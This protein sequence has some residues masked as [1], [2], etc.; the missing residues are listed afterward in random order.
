MDNLITNKFVLRAMEALTGQ[1]VYFGVDKQFLRFDANV[2]GLIEDE[3]PNG[4][5]AR[6]ALIGKQHY[7]EIKKS[8]PI[9]SKRELKQ[10]LMLEYPTSDL[11]FC[12]FTINDF[13]D[14]ARKVTVWQMK[15]DLQS[16]LGMNAGV[17]IPEGALINEAL[18]DKSMLA[19][20]FEASNIEHWFYRDQNGQHYSGAKQGLIQSAERFLASVGIA[21]TIDSKQLSWKQYIQFL[22]AHL[23]S[24]L[25][26]SGSRFVYTHTS[27]HPDFST[28][29]KPFSIITVSILASYLAVSSAYLAARNAWAEE[30]ASALSKQARSVFMLRNQTKEKLA[31]LDEIALISDSSA[32]SSVIWK[33]IGK[34]MQE[35]VEIQSIAFLPDGRYILRGNADSATSV[36]SVFNRS[37]TYTEAKFYSAT[38][39]RKERDHF[40]I[41][42]K[43]MHN[44]KESEN[45]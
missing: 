5:H 13:Q 21:E 33:D 14:G 4:N 22:Q 25:L 35:G 12:F 8:Y 45:E 42:T 7:T 37:G 30:E 34:L 28:F 29:V 38:Q 17:I 40:S 23:P 26:Q 16:E 41:S 1:I 2:G 19:L 24:F 44:I 32:A 3:T 9:Q 20:H 36:L 6:I 31:Q 27:A 18:K 11:S 39:R 15:I 43:L 10:I